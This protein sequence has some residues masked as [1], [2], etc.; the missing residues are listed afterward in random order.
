MTGDE[1]IL[2]KGVMRWNS[3]PSVLTDDIVL[4]DDGDV[5]AAV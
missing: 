1:W 2:E 3:P 5:A 4:A